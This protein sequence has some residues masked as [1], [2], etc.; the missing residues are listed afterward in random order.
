MYILI[1]GAGAMGSLLGAR[2]A[3]TGESISL[4][5]TDREHIE[6]IRSNGL[7][8]DELDGSASKFDLAAFWQPEKLPRNPDLVMVMVKSYATE[9]AVASVKGL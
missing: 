2:L 9:V 6:A 8:I 1:L 3:A 7:E 5:S 4:F